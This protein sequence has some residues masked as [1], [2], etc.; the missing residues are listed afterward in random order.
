MWIS[1]TRRLCGEQRFIQRRDAG[2]RGQNLFDLDV[3]PLSQYSTDRQ[4][5]IGIAN[6]SFP[7]HD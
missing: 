1:A 2:F 6:D 4:G 3:E 5:L 7:V